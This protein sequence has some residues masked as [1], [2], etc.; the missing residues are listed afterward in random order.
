VSPG[1][2][3][4]SIFDQGIAVIRDEQQTS[5]FDDYAPEASAA[6]V[7][8]SSQRYQPP[9]LTVLGTL[10]DLTAGGS[11]ADEDDDWGRCG[12][13]GEHHPMMRQRTR[14]LATINFAVGARG[15]SGIR[16]LVAFAASVRMEGSLSRLG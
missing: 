9:R 14:L 8:D 4:V 15:A 6:A 11:M 12:S 3:G 7:V 10:A 13:V 1:P 5:G 2:V 16:N